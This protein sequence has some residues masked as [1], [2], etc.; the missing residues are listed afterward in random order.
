MTEEQ[1]SA[2]EEE[3]WIAGERE[4]VVAYLAKQGVDH[5]GVGEWPAFH[6]QPYLA[7]W[8]V[9]SKKSEGAIGWWA[10][11]GDA[12]T[13]YMSSG[14]VR[15]PREAMAHFSRQWVEVSDY[16]R[17]GVPHPESK[18]GSRSDWP[19]LAPLLKSRSDLLGSFAA[20][21]AIW[22]DR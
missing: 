6:V 13:D 22:V 14:S 4:K 1:Y 2:E 12:P 5:L 16:M 11:S 18:I 17:R 19:V 15:H 10:I 7:I 8:A 9:Q 21:D 3:S 20:D